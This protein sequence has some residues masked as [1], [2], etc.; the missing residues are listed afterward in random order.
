MFSI[1]TLSIYLMAGGLSLSLSAMLA[2]FARRH[3]GTRLLNHVAMAILML[4]GALAVASF[5]SLWPDWV[6]VIGT[7]IVLIAAGAVLHDAF[8]AFTRDQPARMDA[9]AWTVVGATAIPF[10]YWG[11]VEP[12]GNNRSAVFS[13]AAALIQWRSAVLLARTALWRRLDL[14]IGLM[15]LLLAVV[16]SWMT[17]RGIQ[18]T[19]AETPPPASRGANPTEWTTVAVFM[20]MVTLLPICALWMEQGG[21]NSEQLTNLTLSRDRFSLVTYFSNRLLLLWTTVLVLFLGTIS[22]A[23][24]YAVKSVELE[25]QRLQHT[26]WLANDVL[27][28]QAQQLFGHLDTLLFAARSYHQHSRDAVAT[29]RFIQ[30]LGLRNSVLENLFVTD[31]QGT[32]VAA[33]DA[34]TLGRNVAGK[35]YF[36]LHSFRSDAVIV[37]A[38]DPTDAAGMRLFGVSRALRGP[39]GGFAGVV[40]GTIDGAGLSQLYR[41]AMPASQDVALLAGVDD[42]RAIS[43]A[44]S[45]AQDSVRMSEAFWEAVAKSPSGTLVESSSGAPSR[46]FVYRKLSEFPV[47]VANGFLAS[48]LHDNISHRLRTPTWA[49]ALIMVILLVLAVLLTIEIR[50]RDEQDRFLSMLSHELKTP[51]SVLQLGLGLPGTISDRARQR[52]QQAVQDVDAIVERC[53]Q[54][55]RLQHRRYQSTIQPCEI[56]P[57]LQ[58]MCAAHAQSSRIRLDLEPLLNIQTDALLLR[59]AAVNLL[60]NALKYSPLDSV[61][62]IHAQSQAFNGQ[63]GVCIQFSNMLGPAG[64]P[65]TQQV[66][67]KYYRSPGAR[68]KT[69]SGLGLFLVR[70]IAQRL[71]GWVKLVRSETP[72]VE[73][74]IWIPLQPALVRGWAYWTGRGRFW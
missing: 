17:V 45:A 7:N 46:V 40:V 67:Q 25:E 9:V 30:S 44:T 69:G 68:N 5:K 66:F 1:N 54:V 58:T 52:S 16:A 39:N 62:N 13:F 59:T 60:D 65:D 29:T 63:P 51:L 37:G 41:V 43:F 36:S 42:H 64:A 57:L 27:V 21:R 35:D 26:A 74:A 11:L 70:S 23:G 24:L 71:G 49:G 15:A 18:L 73:F 10:W 20:V 28:Q 48:D 47:L 22:Q 55:D 6:T 14:A 34:S 12:D 31:A 53:L 56:G 8:V 38:V 2:I 33:Y 4:S 61:V 19:L 72:A 3:P 32:V 50:R